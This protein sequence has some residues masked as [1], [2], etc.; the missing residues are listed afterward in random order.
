LAIQ[1]S[2]GVKDADGDVLKYDIYFGDN[3]AALKKI[4]D[5]TSSEFK[6]GTLAPGKTYYWRVVA[7]DGK[8][9]ETSS[10]GWSFTTMKTNTAPSAP[11]YPNPANGAERAP[12]NPVL[13][14]SAKDPDGDALKYVIYFG[15][16]TSA[17][18]K[19]TDLTVASFK[20]G[21]LL[22]GKKYYWKVVAFDGKGGET[23]GDWWSFTTENPTTPN[24]NTPPTIPVAVS[25]VN[26]A[27]NV[28]LTAPLYWAAK[29]ADG[30]ALKYV[31]YFG[32]STSAP[33][34]ASDL[35]VPTFKPGNLLPG[36]KYY[37][38]VVAYDGKGGETSSDWFSFT[39]VK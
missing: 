18:A 22:P 21:T 9:G 25:P 23:S 34:K 26:G 33:A 30:D 1:L 29:D 4:T 36:K 37:W 13:T 35:T 12:L 16:N 5:Q 15:E 24:T 3:T 28:S 2:T 39:T 27:E 20:P 11:M 31:I 38:K 10:E 6:P 17:P 8:G 19:A 14:W 7:K 32:E